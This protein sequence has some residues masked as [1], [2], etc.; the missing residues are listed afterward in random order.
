MGVAADIK[1]YAEATFRSAWTERDGRVVPEPKD[2]ALTNDAIKF[3]EAAILYADLS[4]STKM[5]D[6]ESWGF[7]GEVYKTFLDAAARLIRHHDGSITA[8]DGDRVMGVFLGTSKRTNAAKCGLR[9]NYAVTQIL[10]PAMKAV[11]TTKDFTIKHSVGVDCTVIRAARTG[12]RGDNDIVWIG[13]AANYAAKLAD[14]SEW[15]YATYI[16]KTVYDQM[17]DD[18]RTAANG[19]AMWEART[20]NNQ[21]IYRSNWYWPP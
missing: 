2:I 20:W 1:S 10:Q 5:V 9:I 15:P 14:I 7:A 3:E 17:N 8:Y 11:Y 18:A 19:S 12:V 4:G 16:T 13:R 21:T 6:N